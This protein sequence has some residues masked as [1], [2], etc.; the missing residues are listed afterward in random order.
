VSCL[1]WLAVEICY[2]WTC[3]LLLGGHIGYT[4]RTFLKMR[5]ALLTGTLQSVRRLASI[6]RLAECRELDC[7]LTRATATDRDRWALA[8]AH[9]M[10]T[11][12]VAPS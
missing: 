4:P 9:A 5:Y 6:D 8:L 3:T 1:S 10:T 7:R 11:W 12:M 2:L